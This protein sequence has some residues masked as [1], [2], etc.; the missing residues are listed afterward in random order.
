MNKTNSIQIAQTILC[1]LILGLAP[2]W[3]Y[4]QEIKLTSAVTQIVETVN[5][6]AQRSGVLELVNVRE[7][8][9]VSQ[10]EMLGEILDDASQLKYE[11]AR[12]E[13][14]IAERAARD[15][16][17]V[18]FAQKSL[19]VTQ[20]ELAR[21]ENVNQSV[22]SA[23]SDTELDHLRL[24]VSKAKLE[25]EKSKIDFEVAKLNASLKEIDLKETKFE[26]SKHEIRS[27]IAGQIELVERRAGE[28]I[29]SGQPAFRIVRI[30]RLRAE[31]WLGVEEASQIQPNQP[32]EV[33]IHIPNRDDVTIAGNVSFVSLNSNPVDGKIRVWVEF[34][35]PNK[36]LRPGLLAGV[37]IK[38]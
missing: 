17:L 23:V 9:V 5:V 11:R 35:N 30:D 4:A 25:V 29:E 12:T 21:S 32:A 27:R 19:E 34:D 8:Q 7:G 15:D 33:T 3:I 13:F 28:W 6:P 22:D 20:A 2:H 36:S 31:G 37:V 38:N 1:L 24:L 10:N 26:L 16:T 18:R 14:A